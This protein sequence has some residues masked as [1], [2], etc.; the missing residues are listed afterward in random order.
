MYSQV[1]PTSHS[2]PPIDKRWV[3]SCK[4]QRAP[5][6]AK[7]GSEWV[8]GSEWVKDIILNGYKWCPQFICNTQLLRSE[9]SSLLAKLYQFCYRAGPAD[10]AR[11][12]ILQPLL[13]S[14]KRRWQ[15]APHSRIETLEL[16]IGKVPIQN[17]DIEAN[18]LVYFCGP[19]RLSYSDSPAASTL[20]QICIRRH[21][22][23]IHGPPLQSVS[24]PMNIHKMCGRCSVATK[25]DLYMPLQ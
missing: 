7:S 13:S 14:A 20:S 11:E 2:Q 22:M 16:C 9:F 25:T 4:P 3:V 5:M 18:S 6:A 17:V 10:K 23:P 15:P 19:E 8:R 21:G 1:L 24:G 12:Q